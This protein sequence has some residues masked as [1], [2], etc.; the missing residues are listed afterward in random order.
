MSLISDS[1]EKWRS[2]E[3]STFA[4]PGGQQHQQIS[5]TWVLRGASCPHFC[6]SVAWL[7]SSLAN[8]ASLSSLHIVSHFILT[9]TP[10][11]DVTGIPKTPPGLIIHEEDSYNSAQSSAKVQIYY[12]ERIRSKTRKGKRWGAGPGGQVPAPK[13]PLCCHTG[14]TQSLQATRSVSTRVYVTQCPGLSMGGWPH[15]YPLMSRYPALAPRKQM[16]SINA[17]VCTKGRHRE[18]FI[19]CPGNGGNS[20]KIQ[21]PGSSRSF[22][23]Y[24][25]PVCTRV[26]FSLLYR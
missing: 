26:L 23:G 11:R 1:R 2:Y 24:Q 5:I 25:A 14:H 4:H 8:S 10:W 12:E 13:R 7:R 17:I 9:A 3:R 15:R 16:L 20:P 6:L 19:P 22:S 21:A 18:P